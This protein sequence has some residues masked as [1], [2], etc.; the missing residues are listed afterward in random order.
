M[1]IIK[2]KLTKDILSLAVPSII[3]NITVPLLGLVDLTIVGHI[4]NAVYISAIATGSMTFN[5]IYWLFGF[6]RMGSSGMTAQAYGQGDMSAADNVLRRT[7]SLAVCIGA[8]F[9][10]TQYLILRLML[11]SMNTPAESVPFVA[12][13]FN[14]VIWG[15]PA[16]LSLYAMTGWFIGMQNTRI[17]MWIAIAQNIINIIVST[18][19]V[20]ACGWKIDGVATGTL[21]AQWFGA[22]ASVIGV[23]YVRKKAGKSHLIASAA[24]E[25]S[26]GGNIGSTSLRQFM[27]VNRDI[28]LRTVCLVA[29]NMF[30]T[31]AGGKQGAL[32]LAVNTLLITLYTIFS[33]VMDG[34]AYAA[35]AMCGRYYGAGNRQAF[36]AT[37]T[38][39]RRIGWGMVL[40]FTI[41]YAVGG[42]SLLELLT[43][44][45]AVVAKAMDF[46][47][48][49]VAIPLCG[50]MAFIYDGVFIGITA[51]K[52]ML[53]SSA[54]SAFL[55]FMLYFLFSCHIGNNAL[56]MAF[57]SFLLCRG[58]IQG[59]LLRK[60]FI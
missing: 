56:W 55:F 28:F 34:F 42:R 20:F 50:V 37:V 16:M 21:V 22:L 9:L 10:L 49:A 38:A 11:W 5:V 48:W 12:D 58:I 13:Y 31:S 45:T 39:L 32:I 8:F 24:S 41:L 6:L 7:V 59:L 46:F 53:L 33:Y 60:W 25:K 1:A 2:S 51:T 57:L 18:L 44:D 35:E 27:T 43:S 4:G 36:A 17:T 52:G 40:A 14:I 54:V 47:P 30:F 19:L 26:A 3:S 29:V 15:A 23:F